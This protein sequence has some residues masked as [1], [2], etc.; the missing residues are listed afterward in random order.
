MTCTW[1]W[2]CLGV[3]SHSPKIKVL[4]VATT[5]T[6]HGFID[7]GLTIGSDNMKV[8]NHYPTSK[9]WGVG[10]QFGSVNRNMTC[11]WNGVQFNIHACI[12]MHMYAL[13][14][15]FILPLHDA[16]LGLCIRSLELERER[17]YRQDSSVFGVSNFCVFANICWYYEFTIPYTFTLPLGLYEYIIF[18]GTKKCF[19]L[20][21]DVVVMHA[22]Q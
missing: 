14:G 15:W 22:A 9:V 1:T 7:C 11:H 6:L 19:I 8:W 4:T 17:Y 20:K 21:W 13:N 16:L 2:N 5:R 18:V 3:E 12:V 10:L